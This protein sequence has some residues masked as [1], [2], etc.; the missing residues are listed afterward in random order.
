M[1]VSETA[2][3]PEQIVENLFRNLLEIRDKLNV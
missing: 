2:F 1:F 3:I